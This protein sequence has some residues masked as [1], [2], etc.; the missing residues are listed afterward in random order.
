MPAFVR[1]VASEGSTRSVCSWAPPSRRAQTAQE[2]SR[3]CTRPGRTVRLSPGRHLPVAQR[4]RLPPRLSQG[5]GQ[6]R[7]LVAAPDRV[8]G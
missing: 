3:T 1:Q 6:H 2:S 7:E 8:A 5:G 4:P